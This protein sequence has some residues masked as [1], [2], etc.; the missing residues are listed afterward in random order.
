MIRAFWCI[1]LLLA[2]ACALPS[3]QDS[4]PRAGRPGPT[5]RSI[6]AAPA[7]ADP[8]EATQPPPAAVA[9][10]ATLTGTVARIV[11]GDTLRVDLPQ[12][13]ERVR[14]IGLDTPE[15]HPPQ[16]FAQEATDAAK[17]L[18]P[19]G[20]TVELRL[21]VETRD[22]YGRLLAYVHLP[23]GR[24][25]N[26]E[27]LREGLATVLTIPPN[28]RHAAD[29]LRAQRD[30]RQGRRGLWGRAPSSPGEADAYA[31]WKEDPCRPS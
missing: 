4:R 28:V 20:T 26:A 17:R 18:C 29:F 7:E 1:C 19:P 30:A 2:L 12:G 3:A 16:P 14:L 13:Q 15:M 22:R 21:D 9:P 31:S 8:A 25:V 11:D 5:P 23:D 6:A 24:M 10:N 27:I